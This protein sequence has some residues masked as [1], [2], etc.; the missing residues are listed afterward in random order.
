MVKDRQRESNRL[1]YIKEY[2]CT[3]NH[4]F[5]AVLSRS[6]LWPADTVKS[7]TGQLYL[8]LSTLIFFTA[9][10]NANDFDTLLN[11]DAEKFCVWISRFKIVPN[12]ISKEKL[13][14]RISS[15]KKCSLLRPPCPTEFYT[16]RGREERKCG[17][18]NPP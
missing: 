15:I 8:H 9:I 14:T 3:Q 17:F 10:F 16:K 11:R 2:V 5:L 6:L 4:H 1:F 12:V 18:G 13:L 7:C